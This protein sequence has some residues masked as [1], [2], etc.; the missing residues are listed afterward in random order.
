MAATPLPTVAYLGPPSSYSHQAALECFNPA[1]FTFVP[2][3]TIAD[4]FQAVRTSSVTYGVVPFENSTNGPV[5]QTLDLFSPTIAAPPP[6]VCGEA[7]LNVHHCLLS[8]CSNLSEIT[9]IYSHTQAFG[10][11]ERYLS[12][13]LKGVERIEVTS[14]S[15]AAE[16]TTAQPGSAAIASRIAAD[17]HGLRILS[18]NIEDSADNTTRF[19]I[20]SY[21]RR[22][23]VT[24]AQGEKDKTFLTFLIDNNIPGILCNALSVLRDHGF[25]LTSIANRPSRV[26]PWQYVFFAEFEGHEETKEVREALEEMKKF[27]L[28]L[29]VLGSYR[30]NKRRRS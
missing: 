11:C 19:F 23:P 20:L 16:L 6:P 28:D 17:V 30:D 3:T 21:D 10:Q 9:H 27:C 14:T 1:E 22:A 2:Q 25:N 12:T 8:T 13:H 24:K 4:I 7:Y 15:K 18:R 5:L 29:K 26:V